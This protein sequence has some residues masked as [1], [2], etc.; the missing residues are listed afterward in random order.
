MKNQKSKTVR[1]QVEAR[2]K[3]LG[4]WPCPTAVIDAI[5]V[6]VDTKVAGIV[7]TVLNTQATIGAFYAEA[8]TATQTAPVQAR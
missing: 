2:L 6:K 7:S 8:F 4:C 3:E 5:V 1:E